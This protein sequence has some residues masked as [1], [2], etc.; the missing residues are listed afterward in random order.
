M[1]K[2]LEAQRKLES[3]W[4]LSCGLLPTAIKTYYSCGTPTLIS[5]TVKLYRYTQ[6]ARHG[7]RFTQV[8]TD[9]SVCLCG[10]FVLPS[11]LGSWL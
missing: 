5:R 10:I 7:R 6:Q 11:S 8:S 2:F 1:A 9:V 3:H 4:L